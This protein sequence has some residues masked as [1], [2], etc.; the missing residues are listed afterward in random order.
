MA[1]KVFKMKMGGGDEAK[2]SVPMRKFSEDN[3]LDEILNY[4]PIRK[5]NKGYSTHYAQEA[6]YDNTE[7]HTVDYLTRYLQ[8]NLMNKKNTDS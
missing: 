8:A 2:I 7:T 4:A 5:N 1:K 6:I 3:P